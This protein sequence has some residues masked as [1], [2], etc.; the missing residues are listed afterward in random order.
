M[1]IKS[2]YQIILNNDNFD[3]ID[4]YCHRTDT[5]NMFDNE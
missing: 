5:V 2:I 4:R 3:G 1:T